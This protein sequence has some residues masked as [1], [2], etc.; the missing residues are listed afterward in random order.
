MAKANA[1][2]N[3]SEYFPFFLI[4]QL[5][6]DDEATKRL[7]SVLHAVKSNACHRFSCHLSRPSI[8]FASPVF[9]VSAQGSFS[10]YTAMRNSIWQ[11]LLIQSSR[12]LLT[13]SLCI[14]S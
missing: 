1:G 13:L 5:F 11:S 10:D 12:R 4:Q 7:Q 14:C 3:T 9:S 6:A 8:N 2:L